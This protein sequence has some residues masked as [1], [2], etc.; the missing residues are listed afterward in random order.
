MNRQPN[1]RTSQLVAERIDRMIEDI[2]LT[3]GG[4]G[5][6]LVVP[7]SIAV[8]IGR[9]PEEPGSTLEDIGRRPGVPGSTLGR[10]GWRPGAPRKIMF[11]FWT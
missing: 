1:Y 5:L 4:L 10:I 11:R 2:G 7:G 3:P 6:T 9:R 8:G